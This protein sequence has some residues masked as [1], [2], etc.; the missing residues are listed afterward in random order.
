MEVLGPLR[1]AGKGTVAQQSRQQR[2]GQDRGVVEGPQFASGKKRSTCCKG[3]TVCSEYVTLYE[4]VGCP[5]HPFPRVECITTRT[6]CTG[7]TVMQSMTQTTSNSCYCLRGSSELPHPHWSKVQASQHVISL[8]SQ[9]LRPQ[10][11][12]VPGLAE[13]LRHILA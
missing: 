2:E 8:S 11:C 7:K 12:Q 4:K 10:T 3:S 9:A 6:P 13:H 1:A 5:E